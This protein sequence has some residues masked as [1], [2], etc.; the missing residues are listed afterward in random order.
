MS[1]DISEAQKGG[2]PDLSARAFFAAILDRPSPG[3]VQAVLSLSRFGAVL[4]GLNAIVYLVAVGPNEEWLFLLPWCLAT[5]SIA[6]FVALRSRRASRRRVAR[7]SR[8][9]AQR[10]NVFAVLLGLPWAALALLVF[11]AGTPIEQ[12]LALIVCAGMAAGGSFMMHRTLTAACCYYAVI[13]GAVIVGCLLTAAELLWPVAV[14]TVIY[15]A[16]LAYFAFMTGAFARDREQLTVRLSQAAAELGQAQKQIS[17]LA[18]HD[19]VSGLPNR[20]ALTEQ[21]SVACSSQRPFWLLIIG[22]DHFARVNDALGH[23]LG[24]RFLAV[25]AARLRD[26]LRKEDF[27]ARFSADEYAVLLPGSTKA[28]EIRSLGQRLI[29]AISQPTQLAGKRVAVTASAGAAHYPDDGADAKAILSNAGTAMH[30][31]K[32]RQRGQIQLYLS[33]LGAIK[34]ET[35][36]MEVD[37]RA[38]LE[39]NEF[40]IHYQPK[41]DLLSG[42]VAGAEALL[43]WHHAERGL[44]PP[45][46][47]LPVAAERNLMQQITS[48][49]FDIVSADIAQWRNGGLATGRIAVNIHAEDLK[50]PAPLM[51]RLRA[52]L[53]AGIT[54]DDLYVEVTE[55]CVVGDGSDAA[56]VVLDAIVDLGF[57]LSLDDFGTGHASLSHLKR[58]PVSEIK[59]DRSFVEC[60]AE[61][62]QDRAIVTATIGMARGMGLRTVAEG[63]EGVRQAR[64]LRDLGADLGQGYYW[65]RPMPAAQ[66]ADFV[67]KAGARDKKAG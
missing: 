44:V 30:H 26:E 14:Y 6:G 45:D 49:I 57:E 5:L 42:A 50:R 56:S 36:Q 40:A 8:K 1:E 17:K 63:V 39:R 9:A 37:L 59:I 27:V 53:A 22:L 25:V 46:R 48:R 19:S 10:L 38:A 52:L 3:D 21:L 28:A 2:F 23:S 31:V 41:I 15:G 47:F 43:R 20:L 24:D 51:E 4:T 12:L 18:L 33:D 11:V 66:F 32:T 29:K 13:L 35:D 55:N 61:V 34:A 58:L 54:P 16:S 67:R 64:L 62:P 65:A 60:I 7:V